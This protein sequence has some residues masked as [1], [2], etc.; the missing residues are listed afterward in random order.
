[1]GVRKTGED[2]KGE[3]G[4]KNKEQN[5]IDSSYSVGL[6]P[7]ADDV[8][9]RERQAEEYCRNH[10]INRGTDEYRIAVTAFCTG[11]HISH[12]NNK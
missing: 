11:F 1:M 4:V 9:F 5:S 2:N 6:G 7:S 8:F 12:Q 10:N 3:T